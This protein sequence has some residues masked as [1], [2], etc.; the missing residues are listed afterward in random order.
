MRRRE[1]I[2]LL[3]GTAAAAFPLP[4]RA[5]Q[6]KMPVVGWLSPRSSG[7]EA[8][9]LAV[10]RQGLNE[11]GFVENQNVTIEYRWADGQYDRLPALAA[12][13]VRRQVSVIVAVGGDL[14]LRAARAVTA[15]IPI[16]FNI[17]SD[18]VKAGIV[19]SL[20]RPDGNI[21]G[22]SSFYV[23]L[24]PKR[25]GLM[26][27][28]QPNATTIA[29]LVNPNSP[30]AETQVVETQA[31]ARIVGLQIKVLNAS[32][33][34]DIDAAFASLVQMRANALLVATDAFFFNHANQLVALAARHKIPTLYFRREFAAAGGLMSYGSN[35]DQSIRQVGVYAGRILKGAKPADL[36]VM[37]PTRFEF[38][39]NLKTA[40]AL[41]LKV[42]SS[43]LL[44]ADRVIE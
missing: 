42:A 22:I 3:V 19:S 16:V 38:V 37:L 33:E 23:E 18:P 12:D 31:A 30:G 9:L 4:A 20:A 44:R 24:G 8:P 36:P 27:E 25:L 40:K 15:T 41:G 14:S 39:I 29:L 1:F 21:T 6:P 32:T 5:Q 35:P 10:F 26:H 13:L 11:S 43:V 7:T 17:G 28:L 34:R 2:V